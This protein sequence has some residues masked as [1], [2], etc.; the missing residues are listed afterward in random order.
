MIQHV[1]HQN[2]NKIIKLP[3]DAHEEV[4]QKAFI[5]A[6][7]AALIDIRETGDDRIDL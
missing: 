7:L 6:Q 2:F 3:V 5:E 1:H 4:G